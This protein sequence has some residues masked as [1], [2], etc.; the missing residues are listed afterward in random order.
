MR[1]LFRTEW[2]LYLLLMLVALY[3]VASLSAI[4]IWLSM[5]PGAY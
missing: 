3:V 4:V 5:L 1:A 2:D